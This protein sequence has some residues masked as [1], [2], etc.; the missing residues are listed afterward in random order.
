[1]ADRMSHLSPR[2]LCQSAK[3]VY[4]STVWGERCQ[5]TGDG[6][7]GERSDLAYQKTSEVFRDFGSL[8]GHFLLA[9]RLTRSAMYSVRGCRLGRGVSKI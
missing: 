8:A 6:L 7:L 3:S 2:N 9:A 4:Q 1:M 5:G